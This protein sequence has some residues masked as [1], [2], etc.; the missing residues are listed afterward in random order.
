MRDLFI[1]AFWSYLLFVVSCAPLQAR[2]PSFVQSSNFIGNIPVGRNYLSAG[3]GQNSERKISYKRFPMDDNKYIDW[4]INKLSQGSLRDTMKRYLERSH[5]Y[6]DYMG[7]IFEENGLPAELVYISMAESGFYPYATSKKKA[8]GYWQ[9]IR[10]TGL[11]YGL[12][13]DYLVDERRDFNLSTQAAVRYL[14]DLY[15]KFGD[16][17]LSMAAYNY[18]EGRVATAISR[19]KSRNFWQLVK[20]KALPKETRSYVPKIIAM[21]KIALSPRA[22]GFYNLDYKEPLDY[23]IVSI[24][25]PSSLPHISRALDIPKKELKSLNP[26]FK[27]DKIPLDGAKSEVRVPAYVEGW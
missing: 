3:L 14:K 16:W 20:K 21:R 17:R 22:Y 4:W 10:E 11:Q 12:K 23:N 25:K 8:V 13:I 1:M 2:E 24:K 15:G 18:G 5:R 27:G 9:F 26:K 19:H 7:S 6:L